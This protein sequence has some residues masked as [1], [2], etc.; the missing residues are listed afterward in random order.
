MEG[1]VESGS[2]GKLLSQVVWEMVESGSLR[3][4]IKSGSMGKLLSK[5]VWGNS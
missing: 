3:E 2:M 5:V 4:I 1:T